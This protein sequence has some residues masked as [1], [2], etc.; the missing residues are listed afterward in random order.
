MGLTAREWL[1]LPKDEQEERGKELSPH[2]C[3]L[4][5]TELAMIHFT[6]EEKRTMLKE[7]REKFLHPRVYTEEEAKAAYEE[8]KKILGVTET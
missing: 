6:E 3:F 4:L 8:M 2:E 1:L 5:R 7:E